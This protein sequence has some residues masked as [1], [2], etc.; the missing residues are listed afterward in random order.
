M[1]KSPGQITMWS[2]CRKQWLAVN[3]SLFSLV[4]G[5]IEKQKVTGY[6][7]EQVI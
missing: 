5:K 2:T 4:M 3:Y 7:S 6:A 1:N